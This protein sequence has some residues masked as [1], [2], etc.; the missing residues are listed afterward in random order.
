VTEPHTPPP[1]QRLRALERLV[2]AGIKAGVAIAPLLPGLSDDP[3]KL[4]DVVRAAR[5]HGATFVWASLLYL[6]PGTREHFLDVLGRSW[7]PLA[8]RYAK[9]YEHRAYLARAET[10]PIL[11]QVR[12]LKRR[13]GIA[14]RRLIRLSPPPEP[15]QGRLPI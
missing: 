11:E 6:K 4:A 15:A 1:Q 12:D 13:M 7:P 9:L 5:D 3:A 14:D 10:D 8:E 2:N